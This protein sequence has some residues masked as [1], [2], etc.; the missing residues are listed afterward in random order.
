MTMQRD[1]TKTDL[2]FESYTESKTKRTA[3]LRHTVEGI[4][5][6]THRTRLLY[7]IY[8]NELELWIAKYSAG[9]DIS[10]LKNDFRRIIDAYDAYQQQPGSEPMD[11][12]VLEKYIP[13][14]WLIAIAY[15]L[16][17][18]DNLF[19]RIVALINQNNKDG[20]YDELIK[21]RRPEHVAVNN[22]LH[23]QPYLALYKA[24][25][26]EG[27]EQKQLVLHFIE[28][29]YS[30][31]KDVYWMDI[32][33]EQGNYF[34]RWLFELAAFV[35]CGQLDDRPFSNNAHYPKDLV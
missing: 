5:D 22:V 18:D 2:Y 30:G 14:L 7:V 1:T 20:V 33:A 31:I 10:T 26:A 19:N 35:K 27:E 6:D 23:P 32:D 29:Y 28:T 12:S 17:V 15:L 3:N 25:F 13:A 11:L 34:G 9:V 24:L 21:L 16:N 4:G 8:K